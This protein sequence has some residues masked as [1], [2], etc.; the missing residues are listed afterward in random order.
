MALKQAS[1]SFVETIKSSSPLFTV[2]ISH[3][4][5]GELTGFWTKMSLI[6]IMV[7]LALCSS[8]EINFSTF[9]FLA[10][11]FTN[12]TEWFVEKKRKIFFFFLV[13]RVPPYDFK[14]K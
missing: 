13:R 9:G 11:I 4:L 2:I 6:P 12:L 7:G 10:A 8:F 1:I 5:I 3:V 14:K